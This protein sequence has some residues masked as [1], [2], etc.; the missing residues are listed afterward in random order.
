[1]EKVIG[2]KFDMIG[3]VAILKLRQLYC[4]LTSGIN[5]LHIM[6]YYL[7]YAVIG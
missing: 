1:M 4:A 6:T 5:L 7:W 3:T 2:F